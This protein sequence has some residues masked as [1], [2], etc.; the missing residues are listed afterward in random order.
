MTKRLRKK[1]NNISSHSGH[2]NSLS[3]DVRH[4]A[5]EVNQ[6]MKTAICIFLAVATFS[7]YLQV[8]DHEFIDYDD[9]AFISQNSNIKSGLSKESVIWAFTTTLSGSWNQSPGSLTF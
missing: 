6:T 8:K 5:V 7:V 3:G 9:K 4:L 1:E 2:S